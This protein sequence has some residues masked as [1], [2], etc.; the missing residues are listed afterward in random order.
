MAIIVLSFR[1]GEQ[2]RR[3]GGVR[4][5]HYP[6]GRPPRLENKNHKLKVSRGGGVCGTHSLAD[7]FLPDVG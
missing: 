5:P 6:F 1:D 7:L 3:L 2:R 4:Y